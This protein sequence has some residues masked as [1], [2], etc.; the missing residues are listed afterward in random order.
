MKTISLRKL[1]VIIKEIFRDLTFHFILLLRYF[2][3]YSFSFDFRQSPYK[4]FAI[5]DTIDINQINSIYETPR[6]LLKESGFL[7]GYR[8]YRGVSSQNE[9]QRTKKVRN[10]AY[11]II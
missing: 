6:G 11:H 9:L 1:I 8:F 3:K 7:P 5:E 2:F 10:V 4:N